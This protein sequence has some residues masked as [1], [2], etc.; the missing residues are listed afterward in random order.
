MVQDVG[1][2]QDSAGF[3]AVFLTI[4]LHFPQVFGKKLHNSG[5][6]PRRKYGEEGD[7]KRRKM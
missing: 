5:A 4:S 2:V 6:F 7:E 1:W 3:D